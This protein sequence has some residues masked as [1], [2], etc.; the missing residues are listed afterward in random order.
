MN[1]LAAVAIHFVQVQQVRSVRVALA[2]VR[3]AGAGQAVMACATSATSA[4]RVVP[5]Q[6]RSHKYFGGGAVV[7]K[8]LHLMSFSSEPCKLPIQ[9][10]NKTKQNK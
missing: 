9:F 4:Q 7:S 8:R 2:D 3:D 10:Q 5:V 6:W 1:S